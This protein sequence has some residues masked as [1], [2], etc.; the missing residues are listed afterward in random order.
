MKW[1]RVQILS[2]IALVAA[3]ALLYGVHYIVFDDA[4]HILLWS[5]TNLAFLPI[6][7]LFVSLIIGRL[8]QHRDRREKMEKLNMVIGAFFIEVGNDLL[9]RIAAW[10]ENP[11]ALQQRLHSIGTWE[12]QAFAHERRWLAHSARNLRPECVELE[13]SHL[14][15]EDKRDFLLRLLEN[16]NL[17]ENE[18]FTALL[19][20]VL[21]VAEELDYRTDLSR[22]PV[23]DVQHLAIDFRR[24]YVLLLQQWLQ[25]M[26]FIKRAYPY[27]FSLAVRTNPLDPMASPVVG[28]H[29]EDS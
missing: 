22:L 21:H 11:E 28:Q 5:F 25:Y 13:G 1:T 24:A 18:A 2:G 3:S 14:F 4:H 7:V 29:P 17:L 20:A 9:R 15:L 19:R 8:L 10:D 16:P 27:L 23:E 6:S 26:A 12:P